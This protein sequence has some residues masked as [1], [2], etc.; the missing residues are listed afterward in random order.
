MEIFGRELDF[1]VTPVVAYGAIG[2][3]AIIG[4]LGIERYSQIVQVSAERDRNAYSEYVLLEQIKGAAVWQ[5][6]LED[7]IKLRQY[8]EDQIWSGS[9]NGL[10]AAQLTQKLYTISDELGLYDVNVR[11][12]SEPTDIDNM[13]VL[14][15]EFVSKVQKGKG[16]VDV[17]AEIAKEPRAIIVTESNF[18]HSLRDRR[19]TRLRVS[20]IIPIK[21]VPPESRTN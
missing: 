6:R 14:T 3:L 9:T 5:S 2:L 11:V 20:G 10:I 12:D 13:T 15:F 8:M 16:V 18:A 1:T 17:L 21:I 7:S 4:F 19:P